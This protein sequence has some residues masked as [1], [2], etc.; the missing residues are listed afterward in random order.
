MSSATTARHA[1]GPMIVLA[2]E[3]A[4]GLHVHQQRMAWPMRSSRRVELDAD[5]A[6]TALRWMGA[7]VE[8]PIAEQ[9]RWRSRRRRGS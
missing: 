9:T 2:E 7:L 5:V 1:A 8:P 3:E 6:A 4:G